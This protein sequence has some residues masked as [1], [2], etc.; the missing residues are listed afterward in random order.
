M[1]NQQAVAAKQTPAEQQK[2]N[3][4]YDALAKARSW[5]EKQNKMSTIIEIAGEDDEDDEH[6]ASDY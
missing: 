6:L 4:E 3:D 1:Q 5:Y 2:Q